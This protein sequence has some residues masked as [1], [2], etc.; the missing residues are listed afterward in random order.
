MKKKVWIL[1]KSKKPKLDTKLPKDVF[2]DPQTLRSKPPGV[3]NLN[4]FW[5]IDQCVP[6]SDVGPGAF[7]WETSFGTSL[8]AKTPLAIKGGGRDDDEDIEITVLNP[9]SGSTELELR[10]KRP[11][12]DEPGTSG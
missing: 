5:I 6:A 2:F 12:A 10:R 11:A 3:D 7:E 4:E 9:P 1:P 8:L